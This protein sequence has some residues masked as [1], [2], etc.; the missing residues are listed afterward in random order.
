MH[1]FLVIFLTAVA[2]VIVYATL[3]ERFWFAI[4][5]VNL[6]ILPKGSAE[7]NILH[8][9]DIHMAPWQKRKQKWISK[10]ADL[11]PDLVIDTGD[12]LG[13]KDAIPATLSALESLTGVP[14]VFVNGSNDLFAPSVR[15]PFKYF[16]SP[17]KVHSSAHSKL[18]TDLLT[19]GFTSAGWSDL[20]NQSAT[21]KIK[22]VTL[23]LLGTD[24]AHEGLAELEKLSKPKGKTH[25]VIGVTHAPYLEIL[26]G[27]NDLGAQLIF[28]GHTHGGQ[29]CWP[30][31]KA[32]VTNC[33]L[34]TK[35]AK[36]LAHLELKAGSAFWLNV[37]AGLGN[38]IY[39]PVRLFCRPE[40]ALVTL[41]AMN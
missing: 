11:K 15:N 21:L 32:L 41:T 18:N 33:D 37:C 17:S 38:S 8:I 26:Q 16:S 3:I 24:D 4:R 2:L 22:G 6:A 34:P 29:V 14:G 12:N 7:I 9:S 25:L 20:N 23:S 31:G 40:V 36:G 19:K 10:L 39:A 1:L 13:H 5:R 27:L 35:Y 28:A 30:N